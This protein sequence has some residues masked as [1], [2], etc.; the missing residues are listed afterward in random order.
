MKLEQGSF[1]TAWIGEEQVPR[2]IRSGAG[3]ALL[4]SYVEDVLH[5]LDG[6]SRHTAGKVG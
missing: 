6:K 3:R 4:L 5:I 1:R 2:R